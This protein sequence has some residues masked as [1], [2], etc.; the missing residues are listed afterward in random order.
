MGKRIFR[1]GQSAYFECNCICGNIKIVRS[2]SLINGSSKSCGCLRKKQYNLSA[3]KE[4]GAWTGIKNRCLNK[5]CPE[6]H[7][8]GGRGITICNRWKYSFQNF[9]FDVGF[10]TTSKHQID[11]I[12]NDGNYEPSNCRWVTRAENVQNGSNA[13]LN[14]NK[15]LEIKEKLAK[16][17]RSFN[18]AKEYEVSKQ[19][20]CAIKHGRTWKNINGRT[21]RQQ[22]R[23]E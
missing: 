3:T 8:Y 5:H 16:K 1:S 20:I 15:V 4:Y 19:T 10:A 6:W 11:R 2:N 23:K 18:I 21:N 14:V 17:E 7:R 12:N 22:T 13:K 9:L